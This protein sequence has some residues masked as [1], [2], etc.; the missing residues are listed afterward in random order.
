ME[1][2]IYYES[3]GKKRLCPRRKGRVKSALPD[4]GKNAKEKNRGAASR[5]LTP[6]DMRVKE[7]RKTLRQSTAARLNANPITVIFYLV[8]LH[9][10][11]IIAVLPPFVKPSS[12]TH[13]RISCIILGISIFQ[14]GIIILPHPPPSPPFETL[15][16]L[17]L[18]LP[19]AHENSKRPGLQTLP[20]K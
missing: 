10:P 18:P 1:K 11:V 15:P 19:Q 13:R 17:Q 12:C 6:D 2:Q 16:A 3:H 4:G 14:A 9:L 20:D 7:C 5:S 8:R